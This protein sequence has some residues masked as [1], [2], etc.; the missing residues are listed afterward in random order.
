MFKGTKFQV[1]KLEAARRQLRV[2]ISLWFQGGDEVAIH[3][4]AGAS[5][6]IIHDIV[7]AKKAGPLLFDSPIFREEYRNEA[8]N[9]L[10]RDVNF[11]KHADREP[12][13]VTEFMPAMSELFMMGAIWGLENLTLNRD[14]VEKAFHQWFCLQHPELLT[15]QGRRAQAQFAH[16]KEFSELKRLTPHQFFNIFI[17]AGA[18]L[19]HI[20]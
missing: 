3:T 15:E 2:A 1:T 10:K 14:T 7:S 20:R 12:D 6:Q 16:L 17:Q 4:L 19:S 13:G 11:F 8:I 18:Q 5:Y 9:M